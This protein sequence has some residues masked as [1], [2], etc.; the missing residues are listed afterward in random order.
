M[1]R[2]SADLLDVMAKA[3]SELENSGRIREL[4]NGA[5]SQ[6]IPPVDVVEKGLRRGMDTVGRKYED[7]E[8]FLS[9]LLFAGALMNEALEILGPLLKADRAETKGVIVIGTVRGDIH[10][11]G[12][13]TFR[14]L[15]QAAGF[16]VHDL[17]VDVEPETFIEKLGE[18]GAEILG[19][20]TLLTNTVWEMKAVIDLLNQTGMRDKVKVLLGGNAVTKDFAREIGADAAALDA[21]EGVEMCKRWVTG[22]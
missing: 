16:E 13:N 5:L 20:S 1:I 12:K 3:I 6:G 8:Y 18:T 17:G 14:M 7:G 10:D 21:V 2:M 22:R 15:T 4:V 19:L 9:E 11:I